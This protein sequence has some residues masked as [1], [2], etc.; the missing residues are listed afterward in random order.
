MRPRTLRGQRLCESVAL[1]N[2]VNGKFSNHMLA[3]LAAIR[4]LADPQAHCAATDTRIAEV[5]GVSNKVAREAIT[6]A[7]GLRL[8]AIETTPPRGK[9]VI[10]N[11]RIGMRS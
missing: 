8:I 4:D 5:A 9:R 2:R 10:V 3:A 1:P 7:H 6:R 11:K